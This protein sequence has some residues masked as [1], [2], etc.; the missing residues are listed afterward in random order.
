MHVFVK[1]LVIA[2]AACMSGCANIE[3]EGARSQTQR[4]QLGRATVHGSF[5]QFKWADWDTEVCPEGRGLRKVEFHTNVLYLLASTLSL[6]L[7][8]PQS[9]DWW[10]EEPI[11][12]PDGP[13]LDDPE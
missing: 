12:G 2:A 7:Y 4:S 9:V 10:C 13:I 3:V 8:V 11:P 5:Y 6:G 1:G